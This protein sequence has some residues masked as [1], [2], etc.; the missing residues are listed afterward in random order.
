MSS[1]EIRQ[2]LLEYL[3]KFDWKVSNPALFDFGK[4][5]LPADDFMD[6]H[7]A[8]YPVKLLEEQWGRW[9]PWKCTCE[10]FFCALRAQLGIVNPP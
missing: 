3:A 1:Q 9:V 8:F 2:E 4:P 10:E 7:D 5:D 6:L